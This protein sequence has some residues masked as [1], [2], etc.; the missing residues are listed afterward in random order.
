MMYLAD[1]LSRAHLKS[2]SLPSPKTDFF[3]E[4]ADIRIVEDLDVNEG[5]ISEIKVATAQDKD[6]KLVMD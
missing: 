4:V 6:L 3:D 5:N 1:T 2:S